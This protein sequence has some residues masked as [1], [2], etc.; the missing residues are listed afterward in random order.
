[1]EALWEGIAP[2]EADF[3]I[4]PNG[5][6][7]PPTSARNSSMTAKPNS[8]T[9]KL[10]SSRS[11]KS[12]HEGGTPRS[13]P[14]RPDRRLPLLRVTGSGSRHPISSRL[15]DH[16]LSQKLARTRR[17]SVSGPRK[18]ARI[19]RRSLSGIPETIR[20]PRRS[21][22]SFRKPS[23]THRR[24]VF[25]PPKYDKLLIYNGRYPKKRSKTWQS[26]PPIHLAP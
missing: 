6:R 23:R 1:M 9:G 7:F 17:R 18:S 5:T 13:C 8:S 19:P 3:G 20:I 16:S 11:S 26:C 25:G 4:P 21:N 24:T 2:A 15:G 14:M 22:F 10:P 12:S